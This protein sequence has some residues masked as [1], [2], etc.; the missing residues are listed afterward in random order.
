MT[1][2]AQVE[3]RSVQLAPPYFIQFAMPYSTMVMATVKHRMYDMCS[4]HA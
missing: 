3:L 4:H 2:A 1:K